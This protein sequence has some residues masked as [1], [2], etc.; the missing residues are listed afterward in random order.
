MAHVSLLKILLCWK[1]IAFEDATD[2]STVIDEP[3][4][5]VAQESSAPP[6]P[7]VTVAEDPIKG[8]S[9]EIYGRVTKAPLPT[10]QDIH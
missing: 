10:S 1:Y 5:P 7:L 9:R 4:L 2:Q 3:T 8:P 6:T